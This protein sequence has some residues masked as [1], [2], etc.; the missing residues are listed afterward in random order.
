VVPPF[1]RS[2]TG[3]A[4]VSIYVGGSDGRVFSVDIDDKAL[5]GLRKRLDEPAIRDVTVIKGGTDNPKVLER[6]LD[7]A[8]IINAHHEMDQH[9]SVLA[10]L[11]RALKPEGRL[12]I[13]EPV[14]DARRGR[15]RADQTRDHEIDPEDVLQDA[16]RFRYAQGQEKGNGA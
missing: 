9:R 6:T 4:R 10:A 16:A 8:L 11:R 12:V 7:S 3:H 14:R 13:V 5:K 2:G 1:S 15:P